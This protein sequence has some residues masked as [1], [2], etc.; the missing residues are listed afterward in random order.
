MLYNYDNVNI[1]EL[2]IN[3]D[4][5]DNVYAIIFIIKLMAS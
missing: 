1:K 4:F 2:S 5:H 3:K